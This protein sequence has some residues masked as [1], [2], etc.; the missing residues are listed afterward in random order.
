M[1]DSLASKVLYLR[2]P[3]GLPEHRVWLIPAVKLLNELMY[4]STLSVVDE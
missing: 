2:E 3:G 1:S 4:V